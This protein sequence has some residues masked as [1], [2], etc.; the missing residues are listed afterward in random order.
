MEMLPGVNCICMRTQM[1]PQRARLQV[2]TPKVQCDNTVNCA[3]AG[4]MHTMSEGHSSPL[5]CMRFN[6]KGDLL[7]S[8]GAGGTVI[9]HQAE[10]GE[11]RATI[12]VCCSSIFIFTSVNMS[13]CS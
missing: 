6:P 13:A 12:L 7:V 5:L 8:G 1:K 11:A 4:T 10:P 9:I 2:K 3:C